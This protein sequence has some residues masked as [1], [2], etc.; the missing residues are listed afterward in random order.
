MGGR[1]KLLNIAGVEA[2]IIVENRS[3]KC[4]FIGATAGAC[5]KQYIY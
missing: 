2:V 1:M 4:R 5:I 3:D